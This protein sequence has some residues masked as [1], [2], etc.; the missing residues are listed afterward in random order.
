VLL[1]DEQQQ[2]S[3]ELNGKKKI[4]FSACF[5]E[6]ANVLAIDLTNYPAVQESINPF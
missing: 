2:S 5:V 1:S 4:R 3:S 6:L